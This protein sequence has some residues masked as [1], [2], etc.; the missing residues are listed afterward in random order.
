MKKYGD[1]NLR[2]IREDNDLDFAHFTYKKDQCSCC[3]GPLDMADRYWKKKPV[4]VV[5]VVATKTTGGMSH[6]E[7]DGKRINTDDLQYILFKNANNGSGTKT[8]NDEIGRYTCVEWQMPID[9]LRK[10]CEDLK[11]QLDDDYKVYMPL[12]DM[13]TILI[14]R[15]DYEPNGYDKFE[16]YEEV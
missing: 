11:S 1:L 13:Y 10:V 7:M 9:K 2:K 8:K 4:K 15:R 16:E 5:D 12:N 6:Y 14:L 3:Y